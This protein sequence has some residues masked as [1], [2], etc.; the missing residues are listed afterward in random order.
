MATLVSLP[1]RVATQALGCCPESAIAEWGN[2]YAKMMASSLIVRHSTGKRP[3]IHVEHVV[4]LVS[5]EQ[6]PFC[7]PP[8]IA[9]L[10]STGWKV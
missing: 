3:T 6:P 1:L 9:F 2:S 10:P 4:F 8:T 7:I 5:S